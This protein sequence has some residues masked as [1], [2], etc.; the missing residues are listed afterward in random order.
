MTESPDT[1]D[2]TEWAFPFQEVLDHHRTRIDG[3]ED[4]VPLTVEGWFEGGASSQWMV[5]TVGSGTEIH[6]RDAGLHALRLMTAAS[7]CD[8]TVLAFDSHA[9]SLRNNPTTGKPWSPGEMQA[10]CDEQGFCETGQMVDVLQV[11]VVRRS[12]RKIRMTGI[13][14]HFHKGELI[15]YDA[16]PGG[17]PTE[18]NEWSTDAGHY[19]QM[20]GLIPDALREAMASP[21]LRSYTRPG[22]SDEAGPGRMNDIL[23]GLALLGKNAEELGEPDL[24][25]MMAVACTESEALYMSR[26]E[27]A[28]N[29]MQ[30]AMQEA[31]AEVQTEAESPTP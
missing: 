7:G 17:V 25:A 18:F 2:T 28:K 1:A 9:T 20:G 4:M 26:L 11:A 5:S 12:D 29:A 21:T 10:M 13:P 15:F 23:T 30:N 19:E 8:Y 27:D 22:A 14:Y 31:K 3:N 24:Y 6:T 16:M